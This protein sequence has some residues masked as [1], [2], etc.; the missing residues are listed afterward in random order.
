MGPLNGCIREALILIP[1]QKLAEKFVT[2][3]TDDSLPY[4][5][6]LAARTLRT[7]STRNFSQPKR[8]GS[9]SMLPPPKTSK[10]SAE[11]PVFQPRPK[12]EEEDPAVAASAASAPNP[13]V[14][15]GEGGQIHGGAKE[16]DS[17]TREK[18]NAAVAASRVT[19]PL[20]GSRRPAAAANMV[21]QAATT[22]K[23]GEE[24]ENR[25]RLIVVLSQVGIL[26][27]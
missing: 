7:M 10:M 27:C 5:S 13:S 23:T 25:R 22:V 16:I 6:L 17:D 18:L 4:L 12:M 20:P 2:P 3:S 11:A 9:N 24:K 19:R 1:Q 26:A 21:P 15:T 14:T 8:R